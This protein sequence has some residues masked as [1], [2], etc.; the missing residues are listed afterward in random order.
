MPPEEQ[1]SLEEVEQTARRRNAARR[2]TARKEKES[3]EAQDQPDSEPAIQEA[4]QA[5]LDTGTRDGSVEE[6]P[7]GSE[8]DS[9]SESLGI[10]LKNEGPL[11]AVEE[12]SV[13]A[14]SHDTLQLRPGLASPR[15]TQEDAQGPPPEVPETSATRVVVDLTEVADPDAQVQIGEMTV[16]QAKAYVANHVRRWMRVTLEFVASPSIEYSWPS[17]VP[18]FRPWWAAVMATSEYVASRMSMANPNDA[19]ISE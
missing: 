11:P 15:L 5:I 2:R 9:V 1:S 16:A 13:S 8:R 18:D 6:P 12:A 7:N 14:N 10:K 17:P 3:T 19:W 4:H